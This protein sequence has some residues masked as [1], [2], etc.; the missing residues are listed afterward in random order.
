MKIQDEI[1]NLER[2]L[3]YEFANREWCSDD[4]FGAALEQN[5]RILE[6]E[7]EIKHLQGKLNASG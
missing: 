4:D 2:R 5:N 7:N 6:M 1:D 3:A